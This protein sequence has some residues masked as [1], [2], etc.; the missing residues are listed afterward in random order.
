MI[1]RKTAGELTAELAAMGAALMTEVLD[2]L[3]AHPPEPQPEEG[4][5]YASKIDK[6]EARIDFAASAVEIERQVR[7]FNPVPGAFFEHK[8]ERF[9]I[10]A[11]DIADH[12]TGQPGTVLDTALTIGC[13]NGAIRPTLIQRAGRAAMTPPDLLRGFALPP[14][15]R[16]E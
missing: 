9:R 15:T 16:L 13:G 2:D 6:I 3:E 8:G 7:A 1:Y 14:G 12:V 4:V 11:A 5:T 10:L